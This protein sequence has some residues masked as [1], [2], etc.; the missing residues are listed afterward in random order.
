MRVRLTKH[1]IVMPHMVR[2]YI[3]E[4]RLNPCTMLVA[5]Q[6]TV[7][8]FDTFVP[9][10]CKP[11]TAINYK[12]FDHVSLHRFCTWHA[13]DPVKIRDV[14]QSIIDE[15]ANELALNESVYQKIQMVKDFAS[16]NNIDQSII[17]DMAE[18]YQVHRDTQECMYNGQSLIVP[19]TGVVPESMFPVI[20]ESGLDRTTFIATYKV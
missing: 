14:V 1:T 11:F 6:Q 9:R 2:K 17:M 3:Q 10:P 20:K 5:I 16:K 4:N 18:H 19:V 7:D 13:I 12:Q 8:Q 15:Y